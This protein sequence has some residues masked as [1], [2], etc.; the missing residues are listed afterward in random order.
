MNRGCYSQ[1]WGTQ[2]DHVRKDVAVSSLCGAAETNPTRNDK[3]VGL[4][5]GLAQWDKDVALP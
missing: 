5:T 1:S 4:I 2:E 3:V